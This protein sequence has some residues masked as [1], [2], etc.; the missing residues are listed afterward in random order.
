M[1]SFL[2]LIRCCFCLCLLAQRAP[3]R[4]RLDGRQF[5][6]G[7]CKSNK[8]R[9]PGAVRANSLESLHSLGVL[10]HT[11]SARPF[12]AA[13]ASN[14]RSAGQ[15]HVL[16]LPA[17]GYPFHVSASFWSS[18]PRQSHAVLGWTA[19]LHIGFPALSLSA[20]ALTQL[21]HRSSKARTSGV[22]GQF[23]IPR[24]CCTVNFRSSSSRV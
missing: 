20:P 2:L 10:T 24:F 12:R 5:P 3:T 15:L 14:S 7:F 4:R 16:A 6:A 22:R 13:V 21:S 19:F 1:L 11:V 18:S 17:Y 23:R 9:H 8:G